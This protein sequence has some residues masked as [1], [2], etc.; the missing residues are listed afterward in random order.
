MSEI[1]VLKPFGISDPQAFDVK[2]RPQR[3]AHPHFTVDIDPPAQE[4]GDGPLH[5]ILP[6]GQVNGNFYKRK[7]QNRAEDKRGKYRRQLKKITQPEE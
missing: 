4:A 3:R 5:G 1:P 7:K 2:R 6:A